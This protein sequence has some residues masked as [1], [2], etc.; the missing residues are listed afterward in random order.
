VKS[1]IVLQ[2]SYY[3]W[4]NKLKLYDNIILVR[5]SEKIKFQD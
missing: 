3:F 4:K 2:E 1:T 5:F